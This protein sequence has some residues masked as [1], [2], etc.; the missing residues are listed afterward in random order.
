MLPIKS[1]IFLSIKNRLGIG[2]H[3]NRHHTIAALLHMKGS[4]VTAY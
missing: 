2:L 1:W 3:A 4:G